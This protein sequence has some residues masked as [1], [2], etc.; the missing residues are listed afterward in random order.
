M[1]FILM[2]TWIVR[3]RFD[4]TKLPSIDKFHSTLKLENIT[5]TSR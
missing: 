5:K 3:E 1:V 2:N 4:E